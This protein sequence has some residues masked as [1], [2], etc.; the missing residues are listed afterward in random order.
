[1]AIGIAGGAGV[2]AGGGGSANATSGTDTLDKVVIIGT[3]SAADNS[4]Q[5][6]GDANTGI[7]F[8]AADT[9]NVTTA[10][11]L[12]FQVDAANKCWMT[13]AADVAGLL[14]VSRI[15]VSGANIPPNGMYLPGGNTVGLATNSVARVALHDVGL[16]SATDEALELGLTGARWKRLWVGYTDSTGTPGDATIGKSSGKSSIALGAT[17]CVVTNSLVTATSNVMVTLMDLDATATRVKCV[18]G[19]GSFTVTANAAATADTRFMWWVV[20]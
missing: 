3:G 1:M 8:P 4:I 2:G 17:A 7:R 19:A 18:P 5:P 9:V 16:Y 12:A 14:T 20:N 15:S 11:V 10:G 6:S 13:A